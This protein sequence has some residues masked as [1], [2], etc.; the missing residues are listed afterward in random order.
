[1]L[2]CC[3]LGALSSHASHPRSP[4]LDSGSWVA[5]LNNGPLV[6]TNIIINVVA[7]RR[8]MKRDHESPSEQQL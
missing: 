5:P 2:A 7:R 1:M 4:F 3:R 6:T 8:A